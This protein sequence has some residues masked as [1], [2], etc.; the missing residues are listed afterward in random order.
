MGFKNKRLISLLIQLGVSMVIAARVAFS[1]GLALDA[2]AGANC[3]CLSDGFF[4][5]SVLFIGV[6]SLMWIS[7][8]GFFDILSFGVKSLFI[9]FNPA[10]KDEDFPK[11]YDYKCEQDAKRKGKP[12]N[13]TVLIVGLISL[14]LSL[15][16]LVLHYRLTPAL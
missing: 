14:A 2:T 4:I 1:R 11:Y 7:N 15:L 10:K 16:F 9:I 8:T 12:I 5:S 6:G 13:H 3:G